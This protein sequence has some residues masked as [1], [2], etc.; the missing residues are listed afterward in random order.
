MLHFTAIPHN[1]F[2]LDKSR[3]VACVDYEKL[4]F[5]LQLRVWRK[6][7]SFVPF[8]MNGRK[9]V[10]DFLTD[11]KV[12]LL[13]KQHVLVLESAGE[14]VWVV[15]FRISHLFAVTDKTKQVGKF[16]LR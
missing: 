12:P 13:Q 15:G 10:S 9:K 4:S 3:S 8:G 2:V 6:G 14:I 1:E 7:D 11:E 5:P 16:S